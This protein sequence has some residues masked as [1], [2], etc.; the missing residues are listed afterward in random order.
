[1]RVTWG[2]HRRGSAPM[3]INSLAAL[4]FR[5]G[6]PISAW[7]TTAT[8]GVDRTLRLAKGRTGLVTLQKPGEQ[9]SPRLLTDRADL[10]DVRADEGQCRSRCHGGA[11]LGHGLCLGVRLVPGLGSFGLG[12]SCF[13]LCK[14]PELSR[15]LMVKS[16]GNRLSVGKSSDNHEGGSQR[17]DRE[18]MASPLG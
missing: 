8:P 1:M 7:H 2:Q 15:N 11:R 4:R 5:N 18:R 14:A 17:S 10:G 13:V 12:P 9:V 6:M 3:F 16:G